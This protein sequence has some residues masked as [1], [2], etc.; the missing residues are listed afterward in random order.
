V[1]LSVAML[2]M[3][4][5]P[6][7]A[8]AAT[9]CVADLACEAAG[10]M[11]SDDLGAA[12]ASATSNNGH[13]RVE[14]GAGNFDE[15]LATGSGFLYLGTDP[16]ELVG[17]GVGQTILR[18]SAAVVSEPI[19]QVGGAS[20]TVSGFTLQMNAMGERGLNLGGGAS[21]TDVD[22]RFGMGAPPADTTGFVL[23]G[24]SLSDASTDLAAGASSQSINVLGNPG[25]TI[26]DVDLSAQTGVGIGT[27]VGAEN[28]IRRAEI[29]VTNGTGVTVT[30][31]TATVE[32]SLVEVLSA[33]SRG[34]D[35]S[36][37]NLLTEAFD[38]EAR[39]VTL[40]GP[41]AGVGGIGVRIRAADTAG[42]QLPSL[43][44]RDSIIFGFAEQLRCQDQT[45]GNADF[46]ALTTDYSD[47]PS[48]LLMIDPGCVF[49]ESNHLTAEP[50]FVNPASDFH[51][52][53]GS[54]LIDA[55]TPG[56]IGGGESATDLDGNPRLADGNSDGIARRDLG[57]YE[58]QPLPPPGGTPPGG[59]VTPAPR[60]F[61]GDLV[62]RV[63]KKKRKLAGVLSSDSPA[64]LLGRLIEL[65]RVRK[66]PD[67]RVGT[68]LTR[69]DGGFKLGRRLAPGR[70]YGEVD[71]LSVP[72]GDSCAADRSAKA[73]LKSPP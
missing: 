51:L 1:A 46:P 41:G 32:S 48:V 61:F 64:C 42:A 73:R 63:L 59:T 26:Q 72:G 14:V 37:T 49:T 47:Y 9:W 6:A 7:S 67:P 45:Q 18:D 31:G 27:S 24:A 12:L 5:G 16:L 43:V 15:N 35:V 65:F 66:G 70:Y 17:E 40:I 53:M 3:L 44:L 23:D 39:H 4:L 56:A 34:L 20:T 29:A 58:L 13:D 30:R 54:P 25:V 57:A 2:A 68:T 21:A 22:V 28:V 36:N 60:S 33:G 10:G 50:G 71:P 69:S 19:L 52:A 38:L 55:G 11:H 62:L 8:E